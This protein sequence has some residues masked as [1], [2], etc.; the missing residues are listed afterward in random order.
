MTG[1]SYI[2]VFIKGDQKHMRPIWDNL[3]RKIDAARRDL[4][5]GVIGPFV[6]DEFGDVF[7][8]IYTLTGE[9]YTYAELKEEAD[10]VRDE[11]LRI[12]DAA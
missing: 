4:P 9:G 6:N 12:P 5:E 3:R 1:L 7:G 8:I 2:Y 11:L 10:K